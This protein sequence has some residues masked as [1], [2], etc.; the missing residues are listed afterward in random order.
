MADLMMEDTKVTAIL[1]RIVFLRAVANGGGPGFE[2][3]AP[4]TP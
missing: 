1:G 2:T 3:L 4:R